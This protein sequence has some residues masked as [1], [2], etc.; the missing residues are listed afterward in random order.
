VAVTV[1][2]KLG[3]PYDEAV[4]LVREAP[5]RFARD[6]TPRGLGLRPPRAGRG[7]G[8]QAALPPP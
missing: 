5:V 7:A 3:L 8:P 1:A 6:G 2:T 4:R